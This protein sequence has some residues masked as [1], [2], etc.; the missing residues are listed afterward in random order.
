MELYL[1]SAAT[2]NID[3]EVLGDY[4]KLLSTSFGSTGS[5]HQLGQQ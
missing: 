3:E 4:V 5:L 2:T 1:D